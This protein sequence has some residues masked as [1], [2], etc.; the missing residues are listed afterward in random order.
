M[1]EDVVWNVF[2]AWIAAGPF[3]QRLLLTE[4]QQRTPVCE[5]TLHVA[6]LDSFWRLGWPCLGWPR[7]RQGHPR[8][9]NVTKRLFC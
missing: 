9:K 2:S 6:Q 8:D 1:R 3:G 4:S 5:Q 7:L